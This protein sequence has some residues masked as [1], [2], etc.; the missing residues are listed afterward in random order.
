MSYPRHAHLV[1]SIPLASSKELFQWLTTALPGRLLRIPDGETL[2]RHNFIQFQNAV[3]GNN[4]LILMF[5]QPSYHA[6]KSTSES[7]P[8]LTTLN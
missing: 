3:F 1:G 5:P 7:F 8:K 6:A 2:K 4:P